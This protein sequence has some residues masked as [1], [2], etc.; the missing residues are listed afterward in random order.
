MTAIRH[1]LQCDD[2]PLGQFHNYT[3][4]G[5]YGV[6]LSVSDSG[7][8]VTRSNLSDY[9]T[10]YNSAA[11]YFAGSGSIIAPVPT[12]D[13][14]NFLVRAP[15]GFILQPASQTFALR[16]K[17]SDTEF[18]SSHYNTWQEN[19][20][21]TGGRITGTG[22]LNG[23]NFTNG[24]PYNFVLTATLNTFQLQIATPLTNSVPYETITNQSLSSGF[25]IIK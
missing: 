1:P 4:P 13:T 11:G 12:A 19:G 18:V 16:F 23:S 15:F 8:G 20:T 25:I 10:V 5:V 21:H 3:A 14:N 9:L 17:L 2:G 24:Q 7:G 6:N 22:M